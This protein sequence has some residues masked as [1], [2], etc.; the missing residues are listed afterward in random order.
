MRPA[1]HESEFSHNEHNASVI[2]LVSN[3]TKF[4]EMSTP[5]P[6][7]YQIL[8]FCSQIN[9]LF[10]QFNLELLP[11]LSTYKQVAKSYLAFLKILEKHTMSVLL[12][13]LPKDGTA[14][15]IRMRCTLLSGIDCRKTTL[16]HYYFKTIASI[17]TNVFFS[18]GSLERSATTSGN[19][20]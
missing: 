18:S 5:K 3:T 9:M 15:F 2:Q 8:L 20:Q 11:W 6:I 16:C 1:G 10:E 17:N 4:I 14:L 13:S 19:Q 12:L 7:F